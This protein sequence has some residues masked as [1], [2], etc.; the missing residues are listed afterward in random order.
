M[1]ETRKLL[2]EFTAA[3]TMF[4]GQ[5]LDRLEKHNLITNEERLL[6]ASISIKVV[7]GIEDQG[8]LEDRDN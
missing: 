6:I 7:R 5:A 2:L 8:L 1:K 3:E 4:L